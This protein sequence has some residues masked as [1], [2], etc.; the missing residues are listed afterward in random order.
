MKRKKNHFKSR[1]LKAIQLLIS[2]EAPYKIIKQL[3]LSSFTFYEWLKDPYFLKRLHEAENEIISATIRQC[4]AMAEDAMARLRKIINDPNESTT[5][6][7]KACE[8]AL[9]AWQ[10]TLDRKRVEERLE[11]LESMHE[12]DEVQ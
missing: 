8:L 12:Q 9:N 3:N 7:L 1:Q 2:G 10:S 6:I 11:R 4:V 5:Q